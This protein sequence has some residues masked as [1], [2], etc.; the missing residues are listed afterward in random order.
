MGHCYYTLILLVNF[1]KQ[2]WRDLA[3]AINLEKYIQLL[4]SRAP[5]ST[6][7]L[8]LKW[9]EKPKWTVNSLLSALKAIKRDDVYLFIKARFT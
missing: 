4:E 3:R 7:L 2:D 1:L 5:N 9:A 8:L 6:R